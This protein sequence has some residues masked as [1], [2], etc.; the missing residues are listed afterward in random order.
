MQSTDRQMFALPLTIGCLRLSR[1]RTYRGND[2]S[3]PLE[4]K[5][6]SQTLLCEKRADQ[7]LLPLA[8]TPRRAALSAVERL[9]GC[10]E[11]AATQDELHAL[12]EKSLRW[13]LAGQSKG[14]EG[15]SQGLREVCPENK[16]FP[17]VLDEE[18]LAESNAIDNLSSRACSAT[19]IQ[20]FQTRAQHRVT[21]ETRYYLEMPVIS[22]FVAMNCAGS[23]CTAD[24]RPARTNEAS[25]KRP[26]VLTNRRPAGE[27]LARNHWQSAIIARVYLAR[28]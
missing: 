13:G 21:I 27:A 1:R 10:D 5:E 20:L 28:E 26:F 3:H 2:S 14:K 17:A 23:F 15:G 8:E 24:G 6:G 9:L 16:D 18:M 7:R 11:R 4:A 12:Q 22:N 19:N 25:L